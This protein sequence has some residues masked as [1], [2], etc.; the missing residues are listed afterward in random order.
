VRSIAI[1]ATMISPPG[2]MGGNTKIALEFA[3]SWVE[4]GCDVCVLTTPDGER[5][6]RD[7][8]VSSVR[9]RIVSQ[10]SIP[11]SGLLSA[12]ARLWGE[13]RRVEL[14]HERFD[15]AYSASDFIP[16]LLL[17]QRLRDE[18]RAS[19]WIGCLYLFVPHPAFGYEGHY[20]RTLFGSLDLRLAAFY[21]YQRLVV[22]PRVITAD[23]NMLTNEVDAAEFVRLRYPPE[24]LHAVYGV[25][26]FDHIGDHEVETRYDAVFVGRLHPQKGV[27]RLLRIWQRVHRREPGLRLAI[28]GVGEPSYER[29]LRRQAHDL[30]IETSISWLG[31]CEGPRKYD[32]LRGARVFL[33]T[34]VY[35]NSGMAAAEALACGLPAVMFDLP[36]LRVTYPRGALKAP[37]GDEAVFAEHILRIL[38]DEPLRRSLGDEGRIE[39]RMWDSRLREQEAT[40]FIEKVLAMEPLR[41]RQLRETPARSV[42]REHS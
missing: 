17:A 33:H 13:A 36:P 40:S 19:R 18:G 3:R 21:P 41:T 31:F 10:T 1:A 4:R 6:F 8:G 37:I 24:R 23:G 29:R 25:I 11:A 39:G 32:V 14:G 34:S 22:L 16:D 2:S 20:S 9:F 27:E 42:R 12:H 28:V 38:A 35:D 15:V 26:N 7:Y 30:D 5:T